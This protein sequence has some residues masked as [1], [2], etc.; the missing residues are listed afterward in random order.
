MTL[1]MYHASIPVFVRM[2]NNLAAILAKAEAH[3]Q[4]RRIDPA[5]FLQSR[6]AP[7]MY[8]LVRQVQ[9]ATDLAKGC[10]ARLAGVEAP[11]Y[12]DTETTFDELQARLR[13]C[14]EHLRDYAA[15][16]LDG[17]EERPI[18]LEFPGV[19]LEYR[20]QDYLLNFAMP[21]FYFHVTMAYGILRHLGVELGKVD[22]VGRE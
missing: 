3:A 17:T 15:E 2:L 4:A 9:V 6:L 5:V 14:V 11:R 10:A 16:R 18:V 13:R 22:F 1:S 19:R 7:D 21:N 12:A 8:P 20:G